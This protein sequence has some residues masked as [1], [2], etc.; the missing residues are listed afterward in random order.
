MK[1]AL[2]LLSA[3]VLLAGCTKTNEF[4]PKPNYGGEEANPLTSIYAGFADEDSRTYVENDVDVLWQNGDALSLFYSNCRNVKFEYNGDSGVSEAKFDFVPE[5]GVLGDKNLKHL[6]THGLY[7]YYKDAATEYDEASNSFN[8]STLFPITQHYAPDSFGCGA[9]VMVAASRGHYNELKDG[10]LY[11]R[12]ACG[13][14]TV[15]LYGEGVKVRSIT[16][17][18]RNGE[19]LAG[20]ATIRTHVNE[21]P[22]VTMA[23]G[24]SNYITLDCGAEG[25][26]LGAD[27]ENATEFWFALPPMTLNNGVHLRVTATDGTIFKMETAKKVVIE[28]NKI[29]PMA[30]LKFVSN[31]NVLL[32]T[33]HTKRTIPFEWGTG[34]KHFD[35]KITA[36]YYDPEKKHI[37]VEF[38]TP[39][40]TIKEKA[41]YEIGEQAVHKDLETITFPNSLTTIEKDSFYNTG[42][43]RLD[44]PGSL[45]CIGA[46]AFL[47]CY[48]LKSVTFEPSPTGQ[49]VTI[50]QGGK[51]PLFQDGSLIYINVNRAF[52]FILGEEEVEPSG[53][54]YGL[55]GNIADG[56]Y[57]TKIVI[58]EQVPKIYNYMFARVSVD[59]I[60]IPDHI[61]EIGKGAFYACKNLAEFTV[62]ATVKSIG[63]DAFFGCT[64]LNTISIENSDEPLTLG[65]TYSGSDEYGP[66]YN[67]PLKNIYMGRDII[68]VDSNGNHSEADGWE[69]GIFV[70][71]NYDE[72][73]MV[74]NVEIGPKVTKIWNYM[75]NYMKI[76]SITISEGVAS[77][78]KLAFRSC[79]KLASLT[80][81]ASV[82]TIG[83][84]A[85]YDCSDLKTLVVKDSD[86]QLKIG[87]TYK[88]LF[89]TDEHGP[90]YDSPLTNI[91]CGRNFAL[92]DGEGYVS[93]ADAW[94]EGIFSNCGYE[95]ETLTV[96]LTIG[97]K[98][99]AISEYMFSTL[100]ITSADL[101]ASI[102][103]IGEY[104]FN[105]CSVL[106]QII[107][108]NPNPPTL[109]IA[110]CED[111]DNLRYI[112]VPSSSLSNYK[113]ASGWKTF[114]R[115]NPDG[116]NYF[117][118]L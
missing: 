26:A 56:S 31:Y 43:V 12:N 42:L 47:L 115:E 105:N 74:L 2:F 118:S 40:T 91:Y 25:V 111:C 76:G 89:N 78:G 51:G 10:P 70:N 52:K 104:A 33:R 94:E 1:R 23:P 110:V 72:E 98:V 9:N 114:N 75:F 63:G 54:F 15:K 69:E 17:M 37:V 82:K 85:F 41:F 3:I 44:F 57:S 20:D 113:N 34:E 13:Y 32:Y 101:P 27:K 61:T 8:I 6:E 109:D 97:P 18:A 35:A 92:V 90:F 62:P 84:D 108:R 22:V 36:H 16:L 60:D 59:K 66:F 65:Y 88:G 68:Q 64:S 80:I 50:K 29:Q 79:K 116:E 93:P 55:F 73:D 24:G 81:P 71:A 58:G 87:Y 48:K 96:S 106:Q 86:T 7:P 28:R 46:D 19:S 77:I 45:T 14:F 38:A 83:Y 11:F 21:A 5:T 112:Y 99:T 107:C 49:P 53:A 117:R 102:T 30:A 100:R 39:L 67:S 4:D 103:S 95:D